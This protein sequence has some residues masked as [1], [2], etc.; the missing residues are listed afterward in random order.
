MM[1]RI[2]LTFLLPIMLLITSCANIKRSENDRSR[3]K[4]N[5]FYLIDTQWV[6]QD[7]E[8]VRLS[9]FEGKPLIISMVYLSCSYICPTIISQIQ[10]MQSSISEED[11]GKY[12]LLVIS[13]DPTRDTPQAMRAYGPKHNIDFSHWTFATNPDDGKIREL[14]AL[15]DFKYQKDKGGEFTHS[16]VVALL[17]KN[18][19]LKERLTAPTDANSNFIKSLKQIW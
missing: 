18:G 8:K 19:V 3:Y 7:G 6:N 5:S 16:Y 15:L 13:F 12:Q 17:D 10:K 1:N 2:T 4:P 11:R 9:D 14:A